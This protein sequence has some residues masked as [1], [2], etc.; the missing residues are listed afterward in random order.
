MCITCTIL[1]K[2]NPV[3][4]TKEAYTEVALPDKTLG[5][6]K[7]EYDQKAAINNLSHVGC[8]G[9]R[10]AYKSQRLRK[11]NKYHYC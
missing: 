6:E 8:D 11:D 7:H 4:L 1:F 2:K 5:T 10:H 9:A 3:S